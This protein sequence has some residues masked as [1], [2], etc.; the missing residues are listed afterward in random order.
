MWSSFDQLA[1]MVVNCGGNLTPAQMQ[2][3]LDEPV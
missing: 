1:S 2:E 3:W